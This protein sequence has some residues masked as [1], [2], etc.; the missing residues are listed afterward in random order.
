MI[1]HPEILDGLPH[2]IAVY[3]AFIAATLAVAAHYLRR[4]LRGRRSR[5]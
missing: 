5:P 2:E 3:F 1:P 4:S